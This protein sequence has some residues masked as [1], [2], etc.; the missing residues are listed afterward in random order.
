M[1]ASPAVGT[2]PAK[3]IIVGEHFV[4]HGKPA[5]AMAIGMRSKVYAERSGKDLEIHS[6]AIPAAGIFGGDKFEEIRGGPEAEAVLKPV[7]LA[8]D[9]VAAKLGITGFG[10]RLKVDS[11]IPTGVGLGS[12]ASVAVSTIS[13]T[14]KAFGRTLSREEIRELASSSEAH[15]HGRPSGIDQTICAHGG[16]ITYWRGMG[17]KHA[18][19]AHA[20]KLVVG[21]TRIRRSTGE[22]VGKVSRFFE[23]HPREA[24]RLAREAGEIAEE[25]INAITEGD[26][27]KL[28][29][30]MDENQI[31]LEKVGVSTPELEKLVKAARGAGALG[32]KLTGGG[33]GGCMIALSRPEETNKVF[34]AIREVGGDAYLVE[35]DTEGVT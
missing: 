28:G 25:A 9:S 31:L 26:I 32:A 3:V 33:G 4:V 1:Y 29:V 34:Q 27:A 12:S 8:A 13:A 22:M 14:A 30:L 21:N 18:R 35:T 17:F 6:N 2:A 7:K 19:S 5:V 15:A 10:L 11:P 24:E 16:I 20:L 23:S